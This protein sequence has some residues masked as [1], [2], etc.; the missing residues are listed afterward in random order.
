MPADLRLPWRSVPSIDPH[1]QDLPGSGFRRES[2]A[3]TVSV[4]LLSV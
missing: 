4:Q 2:A 1:G 3:P